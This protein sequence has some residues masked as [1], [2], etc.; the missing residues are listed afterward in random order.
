MS[1]CLADRLGHS[2]PYAVGGTSNNH[3]SVLQRKLLQDIVGCRGD[4]LGNPSRT[5]VESAVDIE[6]VSNDLVYDV[7]R[8]QRI[9]QIPVE[10]LGRK[11]GPGTLRCISPGAATPSLTNPCRL[12]DLDLAYLTLFGECS[13]IWAPGKNVQ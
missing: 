4:W 2:E 8:I 9:Q 6:I 3:Y 7:L 12:S 13:N 5:I 11:E 1:S 10:L